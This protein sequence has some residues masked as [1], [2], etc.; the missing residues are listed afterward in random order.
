MR[1]SS[2]CMIK[3]S[4][5]HKGTSNNCHQSSGAPNLPTNDSA[6]FSFRFRAVHAKDVLDC[7]LQQFFE[8]PL[9]DSATSPLRALAWVVVIAIV[10][11]SIALQLIY[12]NVF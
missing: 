6:L 12:F 2:P 3:D 1:G 9:N 7:Q 8:V 10:G 4:Q 11:L 5:S